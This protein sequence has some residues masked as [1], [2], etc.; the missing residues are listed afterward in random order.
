MHT[1]SIPY[2]LYNVFHVWV[3]GFDWYPNARVSTQVSAH[4]P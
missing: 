1:R 4:V 2:L 3:I